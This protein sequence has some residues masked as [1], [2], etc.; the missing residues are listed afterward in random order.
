M[1]TNKK[2]GASFE[3]WGVSLVMGIFAGENGVEISD[4]ITVNDMQEVARVSNL[5]AASFFPLS[6]DGLNKATLSTLD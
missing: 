2:G 3:T 1:L 6:V 4:P 5:S